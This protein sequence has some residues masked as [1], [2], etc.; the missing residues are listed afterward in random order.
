MKIQS[1]PGHAPSLQDIVS[2]GIP[3]QSAPPCEGGGLV[4]VLDL[5]LVPGPHDSLHVVQVLHV[6]Q[7][8]SSGTVIERTFCKTDIPNCKKCRPRRIG[9]E[10]FAVI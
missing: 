10:L 1:K 5:D 7:F 2:V 3:G 4:H 8:P 6:D 9:L